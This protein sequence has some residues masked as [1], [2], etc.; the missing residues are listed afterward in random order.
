MKRP[1]PGQ[2]CW[3]NGSPVTVLAL[4]GDRVYIV[5]GHHSHTGCR[6]TDLSEFEPSGLDEFHPDTTHNLH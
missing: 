6:V 1:R 3:L 2:F 4:A 5:Y